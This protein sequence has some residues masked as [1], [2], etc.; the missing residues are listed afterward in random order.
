MQPMTP[1]KLCDAP[2]LDTRERWRVRPFSSLCVSR[3]RAAVSGSVS[4]AILAAC[5]HLSVCW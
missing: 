4:S 2:H 1:C 3:R 5:C